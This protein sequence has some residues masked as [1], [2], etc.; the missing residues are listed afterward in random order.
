MVYQHFIHGDTWCSAMWIC[1]TSRFTYF[2]QGSDGYKDLTKWPDVLHGFLPSSPVSS[3]SQIDDSLLKR[4]FVTAEPAPRW[5]VEALRH[6]VKLELTLNR[7]FYLL[8]LMRICEYTPILKQLNVSSCEVTSAQN[9]DQWQSL[10]EK[11]EKFELKLTF[12]HRYDYRRIR[13]VHSRFWDEWN[14]TRKFEDRPIM[15]FIVGLDLKV[16]G[17]EHLIVIVF[18]TSLSL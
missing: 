6:C 3:Q 13:H 9:V 5:N 2:L 14:S 16:T 7:P 15:R 11:L 1:Q 10:L 12:I 18:Q 4:I 8:S 17:F